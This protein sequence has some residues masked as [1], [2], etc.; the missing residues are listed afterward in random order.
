MVV[1]NPIVFSGL[2]LQGTLWALTTSWFEYWHPLTWLSHMLDCQLFG[3]RAGWHHLGNL[4]FH[5]SNTVLVFTILQRTTALVWRGAIV[6]ALFALHP[7][8]VESVA[9]IAERKDVLSTFFFLLTIWAYVRNVEQV[10]TKDSLFISRVAQQGGGTSSLSPRERAGVRGSSYGLPSPSLRG[11]ETRSSSTWYRMS[12]VFF[13]FA[14]MSKP[15]V[16]TLP[17]V[18][19]LMDYWPLQRFDLRPADLALKKLQNLLLEKLP[20]FGLSLACSIVTYFG[21]KAGGNLLP[22]DMVPLGLRLANV[23][24]SYVRYIGKMFWPTNLVVLNPMPTHWPLW[25]V[26]LS[27]LLLIAISAFVLRN[28]RSVPYLVFGWFMFL[29]VLVPMIGLVQVGFHSIADRYTYIPLLGLFVAVVWAI[30][31]LFSSRRWRLAPLAILTG[32]VLATCSALTWRQTGYWQNGLTLWTHC[33]AAAPETAIARYNLG[34]ALQTAGKIEPAMAEY[35]KALRLKPDHLDANLNIGT[36]LLLLGR[37]AE[38]T[39]YFA[40]ALELKP[41]YAK[42]HANLGVALRELGDYNGAMAQCAEAIRLAPAEFGA[43]VDMARSL[44]A[45]G[46][47]QEAVY[48]FSEALRLNPSIPQ[49]PF[50]FGLDLLKLGRVEEACRSFQQAVRLGPNWA[51]AHTQLAEALASKGA[52]HQAITEY[53]EALKLNAD[54]VAALNNLAWMLAT[55]SD[56]SLRDG[57]EAVRLAEQACRL[58]SWKQ[59]VFIGTLAAAYAQVGDFEKAVATS[60][61]ACDLAASL[62]ETN[63]LRRNQELLRQ[64]ENHQPCREPNLGLQSRQ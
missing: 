6:A 3:L 1:Q 29:G 9:W 52:N 2:T 32:L 8:H 27:F 16:V 25:Q 50:Y 18:L 39:N 60:K 20:F 49:I 64:F 7:L 19:L 5:V 46:R 58:T 14:L 23:P 15:M 13:C 11:N 62:S 57:A 38:A 30:A 35:Q 47:S 42:A 61:Q 12:L 34:L 63:L 24:I 45:L 37:T 28:S 48:Y 55:S 51:D 33:L 4:A 17:F 41:D 26:L 44:S 53:H 43:Y 31:D 36:S 21:V 22:T 59:T 54:S 56:A 10:K 40:K